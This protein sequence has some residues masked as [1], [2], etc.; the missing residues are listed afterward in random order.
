MNEDLELAGFSLSPEEEA[1]QQ[2]KVDMRN[3]LQP[4]ETE[5]VL[6]LM[7]KYME[8]KLADIAGIPGDT[9]DPDA[10]SLTPTGEDLV[11]WGDRVASELEAKLLELRSI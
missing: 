1:R 8:A 5:E 4:M 7:F 6:T 10:P 3:I 9:P 11:V 2:V